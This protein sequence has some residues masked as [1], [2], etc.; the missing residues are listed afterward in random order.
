[1]KPTKTQQGAPTAPKPE[2]AT[3]AIVKAIPTAVIPWESTD[4]TGF[5]NV[6]AEDLG[7]PFLSIVQKGS[8]EFDETHVR[9]AD[10]AIEGVKP[11][12]IID[13][14]S[15]EIVFSKTV[16]PDGLR[17]V[18]VFWDKYYMEWRPRTASGGGIVAAH[19][20]PTLV[21]TCKRNEKNQDVLPN[22]NLL[23]TTAYFHLVLL[24]P[25]ADVVSRRIMLGF[26]STQLKKSR[27]WLNI[28]QSLRVRTA[29]GVIT[30]P[31]YSHIYRLGTQAESNDKGSWFGW[32]I[33]IEGPITTGD[34]AEEVLEAH[35]V[36]RTSTADT[37]VRAAATAGED[38]V[39]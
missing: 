17:V 4:S 14:L 25:E 32:T 8:A 3:Q 28:A 21:S 30:P 27:Q 7:L 36:A 26:S 24:E 20:D 18:P 37:A 12:D 11:G 31:L 2:P 39:M 1:M 6:R 19:K 35:R 23:V 16:N 33:K 10:K 5:E 29:N 34:L 15:R 38:D 22:G 9:H 13:I